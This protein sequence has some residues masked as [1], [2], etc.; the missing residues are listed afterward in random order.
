MALEELHRTS[1]TTATGGKNP[2][3]R[4]SLSTIKSQAGVSEVLVGDLISYSYY[5]YHI[6]Y[7][8]ATYAYMDTYQSIRGAA[9]T[10]G[11]TPV[12]GEDYFTDEDK[13]EFLNSLP[14]ET[15]VFELEDGT[16]IEK[17]VNVG[18]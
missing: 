17:E 3:K 5:H 4:M 7:I 6:Y 9:G 15:W 11:S 12:K 1:S 2:I 13:Q 8:D 16:T 18:A 14:S 10:N